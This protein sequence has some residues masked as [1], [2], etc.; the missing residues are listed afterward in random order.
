MSTKTITENDQ[1]VDL[2]SVVNTNIRVALALR[3]KNQADLSAALGLSRGA[4]YRKLKGDATWSVPDM[5]KAGEF[6]GIQP[7]KFLDPNGLLVAGSGFEPET[8]GL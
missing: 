1:T 4:V 6:L 2:T 7:A 5:E 8:S 3:G